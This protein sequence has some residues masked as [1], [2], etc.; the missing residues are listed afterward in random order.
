MIKGKLMLEKAVLVARFAVCTRALEQLSGGHGL[1]LL[2][3][4]MDGGLTP[5]LEQGGHGLLER[6]EPVVDPAL[7]SPPCYIVCYVRRG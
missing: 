3:L 7:C 2:Q 5:G 1:Q 4:V 6:D